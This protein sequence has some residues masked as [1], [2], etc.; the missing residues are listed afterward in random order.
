MVNRIL[1][2]ILGLLLLLGCDS[3]LADPEPQKTHIVVNGDTLHVTRYDNGVLSTMAY[4]D[5]EQL[6]AQGCAIKDNYLYR[7]YDKGYCVV[8]KIEDN[9]KLSYVKEFKLGSFHSGNHCNCAQFDKETGLLYVSEFFQSK[10]NVERISLDNGTSE[11]IQEITIEKSDKLNSRYL[12]IVKGDDGFMW[13][14]GGPTEGPETL[15]FYKFQAPDLSNPQV[16]LTANDIVD[17]WTFQDGMYV[18]GGVVKDK[19]LFFL[20]GISTTQKKIFIFDKETHNLVHI[21]NLDGVV[22]EE[23]EDL[24]FRGNN[25]IIT[26][27]GGTSFYMIDCANFLGRL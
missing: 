10:C 26:I 3:E 9:F 25:L 18:Q 8:F 13:A 23:P 27:F 12:N 19:F 16:T 5:G 24:D 11:L 15:Y 20:T 2:F 22:W 1:L 4:V 17:S 6:S 7:F 21:L 14:M